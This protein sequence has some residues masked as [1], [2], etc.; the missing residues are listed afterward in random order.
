MPVAVLPKISIIMP[1]LNREHTIEKAIHSLLDQAYPDLE[2]IVIDGGSSDGTVD[3]IKRY[4]N[5][6]AYWHSQ[7]DGGASIA[8]NLGVE[9]A[10]GD[11]I[12][13]LMADDWYEPGTLI[14]IAKAMIDHPEADMITCGGKI[15]Y[16]DEVSQ[17]YQ[18]KHVY[19]SAHRMELNFSNICFD[20]TSAICCRFIKKSLYDQIGLFLPFD[21]QGKHM[22]SNDKE[23]LLRAM[24]HGAKNIYVDYVGHNY[25]ASKDSSTFGNHKQ[26]I[27][28]LCHEHM[29]TAEIYLNTKSMSAKYTFLFMYW[30]ID[31]STRLILFNML[32]KNVRKSIALVK[33][34]LCKFPLLWTPAF[35]YTTFKIIF[36]KAVRSYSK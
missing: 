34:G 23:F 35:V 31:Q 1:V 5:Y 15:V 10:T 4:Q 17:S 2:F 16:Y 19:A 25:L 9:H 36:K 26:N 24:L 13:F 11:L 27:L 8:M 29:E 21:S 33:D 6:I 28:R 22:F 3:I 20:I 30:Y 12:A 32:D 14:R 7:A 18:P